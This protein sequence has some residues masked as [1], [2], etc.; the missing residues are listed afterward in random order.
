MTRTGV[1][2]KAARRVAELRRAIEEHN[3][4]YYV[5]DDPAIPDAEYDAL[6]RELR[7]L[8][9]AHPEL[10]SGDSPTQ[11][12]G[13]APAA[14]FAE[15]PHRIPMLSLDNAFDEDEVRDFDRRVSERLGH[16]DVGYAAELKLDG[17]AVSILYE[18]GVLSRAATRGDGATG[19]D[20]TA[21]MRTIRN[22]PLRLRMERA[23][24][25]LE[26]RGEV[27]LRKA[28]FERLNRE[29]S[30]AGQRT[31]ANPRNAAAGSLRQLD[32]RVTA[33][34][35]L[36]F[37][38]YGIGASSEGAPCRSQS[39][40]PEWLRKHGVPV[41]P[42]GQRVTGAEG[43]VDYY[44]RIAAQRARL[45]FDI[46]GVVFKVDALDEQEALGYVTRAPRWAV[47]AKFPPEEARTR[48]LGIEV[49][50]GRTG[51]LT[52]VARLEPVFVGGVTVT[53]ATLH[54]EDEVL[55]KDV[56]V[57]DTVTVRRAGDVIP[58][59]TGVITSLRPRGAHRF[60][61]PTSCPECGS[62]VERPEGEAVARCT[63]G[64]HCPA[65]VIQAILHFAGRRAMNIDKLGEKIVERLFERG[66]VKN[67]SDIYAL[68]VETLAEID[69]MGE[70]SARNLVDAIA[71]SRNTRLDRFLFALGIRDVGEA[72]AHALAVHFGD[73]D[74]I[75]K[76]SEEALQQVPDVGPVV[77][78]HIRTFMQDPRNRAIIDELRTRRGVTWPRLAPAS[79][80][81]NLQGTTF[82]LTGTL[83]SM[84]RDEARDRLQAH[85]AKVAGSVSKRTDY[86]VAGADP[87]SK[88]DQARKLGIRIVDEQS[89]LKLLS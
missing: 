46:D 30:E 11:R 22:V 71:G 40:L 45:P 6:F 16:G 12:V 5:L 47:A 35:P 75:M 77:A 20:V 52:P 55:R 51:A 48:V 65:Q 87:G 24:A 62:P 8:E 49:Q 31:F 66:L 54:N 88:L 43:C 18:H 82:V 74:P 23:P 50:V 68:D 63:G 4:R 29:Q 64:L 58:E 80:S 56:R 79:R 14:A 61:M 72:T 70:K 9:D 41:S 86:V 33:R 83:E 84:T 25:L 10:V 3:Y 27:I 19:E 26:V 59:V 78:A 17:L 73:L 7:A 85:G 15:V 53:N 89:F 60:V 38:A 81:G 32:A 2:S 76:A 36:S 1:H 34:R 39:R 67:V 42:L 37:L 69:R 13:A 44:R 28:D 57:G 21:N